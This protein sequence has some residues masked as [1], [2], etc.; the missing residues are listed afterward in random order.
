[1]TTSC[2]NCS[3]IFSGNYC[4]VCGQKATVKRL[5]AVGILVDV[6]TFFTNMEDGF[7]YTSWNFLIKPGTSSI[8]YLTGKRK[9]YQKPVSFF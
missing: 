7:L 6:F 3:T 5:T 8:Q 4:P 1:M 2:L 9:D